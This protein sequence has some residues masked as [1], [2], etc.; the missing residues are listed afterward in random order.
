M[1]LMM[2]SP[3]RPLACVVACLALFASPAY[4]HGSVALE[5]DLCAIKIGY[6]KA[7]FKIYLPQSHEHRDF[8]EDLPAAGESIFVMEYL[9]RGLSEVPI[10]FRIVRN[11]TG[12]GS[13]ARWEDL[14]DIENLDEITVFYQEPQIVPDVFS[15]L[16]RFYEPGEYIGIVTA[17]I[18]GDRPYTAVF[19]FEVGFTGFGYWPIIV[20]LAIALQLNY[21]FMSGRF[22]RRRARVRA[23][24]LA[25]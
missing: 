20:L 23:V 11:V 3:V 7:H 1:A 25:K 12:M 9:H 21:W 18:D 19:P 4:G 8:C 16:Y 14:A 24:E 2:C 13:F 10:D 17:S 22:A 6:L 15:V 5:D